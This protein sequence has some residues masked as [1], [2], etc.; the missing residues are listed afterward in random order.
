MSNTILSSTGLI[1]KDG[2]NTTTTD[3][4][5]YGNMFITG[6]I[7]SNSVTTSG[8]LNTNSL[9]SPTITVNN[10]LTTDQLTF[11]SK[12]YSTSNNTYRITGS[13]NSFDTENIIQSISPIR[14]GLY[15]IDI[16]FFSE[17][18]ITV[19]FTI[20]FYFYQGTTKYKPIY[21]SGGGGDDYNILF[22]VSQPSINNYR[23]YFNFDTISSLF[24][25]IDT[26]TSYL[27]G[28]YNLSY[29]L[30]LRYLGDYQ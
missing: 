18:Q 1:L 7:T 11:D 27:G 5:T 16:T 29:N 3:I 22:L 15:M 28:G 25:H 4:D 23:L 14:K 9:N 30:I 20:V 2:S 10:S 26:S 12:I 8:T 19:L 21:K 24:L 17:I 6:V 13:P